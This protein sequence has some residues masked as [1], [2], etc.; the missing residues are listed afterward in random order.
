MKVSI[1]QVLVSLASPG[2]GNQL[3]AIQ[4]P[5]GPT[6]HPTKTRGA[7]VKTNSVIL[8]SIS[9]ISWIFEHI[10]H[11]FPIF[12]LS[13][14][15]MSTKHILNMGFSGYFAMIFPSWIEKKAGP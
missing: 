6:G 12:E 8:F 3:D 7:S 5:G 2:T 15:S 11:H 14:Y 4:E 10:F 1:S 9:R 13:P